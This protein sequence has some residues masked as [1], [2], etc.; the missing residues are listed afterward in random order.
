L[1]KA[2]L[3]GFINLI[4]GI[5]K[6]NQQM[7]RKKTSLAT[8]LAQNAIQVE[9]K[10]V[11]PLDLWGA[12]SS[13]TLE[14]PSLPVNDLSQKTKRD[15]E[16]LKLTAA[17]YG[18]GSLSSIQ[19]GRD[20]AMFVMLKK[21]T[22]GLWLNYPSSIT[23]NSYDVF[24]NPHLSAVSEY[25]EYGWDYCISIPNIRAKVK[26]HASVKVGYFDETMEEKEETLS[27]FRARVFQHELNHLHGSLMID[28]QMCGSDTEVLHGVSHN[29]S[30][31]QEAVKRYKSEV[32]RLKE[33]N[34][35]YFSMQ[36]NSNRE[37]FV[38]DATDKKDSKRKEILKEDNQ[39]YEEIMK[40]LLS[41]AEK[42]F[43]MQIKELK[44]ARSLNLIDH[45]DPN[46][47][48]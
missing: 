7:S 8:K 13:N 5:C 16:S 1:D 38:D 20:Y 12:F 31:L 46:S 19:V 32:E 48:L 15:I 14:T 34:P 24:I 40:N 11:Q 10:A 18:V 47:V 43:E 29:Y 4:L 9:K 17:T 41:S 25:S 37:E 42:D 33:R 39:K 21:L 3:V 36:N 23:P 26:Y 27:G 44:A 45:I 22:P 30:H 6:F 35:D 28:P 2:N